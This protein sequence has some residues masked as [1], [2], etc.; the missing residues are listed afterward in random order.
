MY[1]FCLVI[2]THTEIALKYINCKKIIRKNIN[3]NKKE[4]VKAVKMS[5]FYEHRVLFK[6]YEI[7]PFWAKNTKK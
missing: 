4:K 6:K 1:V 7:I 2:P 5:E 3:P